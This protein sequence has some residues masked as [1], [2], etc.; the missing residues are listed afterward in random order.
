MVARRISAT[1]AAAAAAHSSRTATTSATI[2]PAAVP[3]PVLTMADLFV[4]LTI[5]Q[6]ITAS[7]R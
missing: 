7:G 3:D 1:A 2:T 4:A 6:L 5:A